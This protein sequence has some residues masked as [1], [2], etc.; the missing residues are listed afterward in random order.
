V[1][2]YAT[3]RTTPNTENTS[4]QKMQKNTRAFSPQRKGL[5][6]LWL[7]LLLV[8]CGRT[9]QKEQIPP[10]NEPLPPL[11][12]PTSSDHPPLRLFLAG[13]VNFSWDI[14]NT[15]NEGKD[16]FAYVGHLMRE[17][18]FC[19]VNL[20]TTIATNG[21]PEI[22]THVF[23]SPPTVLMWLTN[24]GVDAVSLANN[25]AMDYGSNALFEMKKH[26]E[27]YGI[28]ATG[29]GKNRDD[30][31]APIIMTQKGITIGIICAGFQK[32]EKL[33]ATSTTAGTAG[34]LWKYII[35]KIKNLRPHVDYL[36]LFVHWGGEYIPIP[37]TSDQR[38]NAYRAI[39]TGVD[40]IVG[41]HPHIIQGIEIYKGKYIFYSVG[42][43]LFPQWAITNAR[44]AIA[45]RLEI[46]KNSNTLEDE[47]S[48]IPIYR[49]SNTLQPII[50]TGAYQDEVTNLLIQRSLPLENH[51]E[52][53]PYVENGF[54]L[55]KVVRKTNLTP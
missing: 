51:W 24:A 17:S 48:I 2:L 18:D 12:T 54:T 42:N 4:K 23:R 33:L 29:A 15:L 40:L 5:F 30:A 50:A 11:K 36:I 43:F 37:D 9:L 6:F 26:L 14:T 49:L 21:T 3:S 10:Q 38:S 44:P 16:P 53:K 20:E 31:F 35:K 1:L 39:D 45:L 13:D 52:I 47:I 28:L 25:H 34:L 7:F 19:L 55:W 46:Q 32:P 8:G 22:K 41:H 27:N